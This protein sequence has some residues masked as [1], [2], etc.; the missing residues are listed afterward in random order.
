[1]K[2]KKALPEI[3]EMKSLPPVVVVIGFAAC[4]KTTL[5]D[6]LAKLYPQYKII[7]TDGYMET[8]EFDEALYAIMADVESYQYPHVII[9][10]VQGYRYLRKLAQQNKK[11]PDLVITCNCDR[12]TRVT[13]ITRRD[14]N[15]N[16]T[17]GLDKVLYKVWIDYML[18]LANSH[19]NYKQPKF[20][21]YES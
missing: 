6:E 11:Q 5:T 15:V 13:R 8:Y 9:E 7:N 2:K 20:I 18:L 17:L 14:K 3:K 12:D 4:G 21:S 19:L 16:R 10:G 1:M